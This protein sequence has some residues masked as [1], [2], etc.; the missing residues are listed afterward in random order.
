[1]DALFKRK[2][3]SLRSP[4]VPRTFS[5]ALLGD[6]S[7]LS[8]NT[9]PKV[10]IP[11]KEVFSEKIQ[12]IESLERWAVEKAESENNSIFKF[13]GG[14]VA[15][16]SEPSWEVKGFT[17]EATLFQS[18]KLPQ[19]FKA[20]VLKGKKRGAVKVLFVSE[21]FRLY[22]EVEPEFKE[23]FINELIVGFPLKTAELFERMIAA[24]KLTPEE[25]IIF[26]V[27]GSDDSDYSSDVMEMAAYYQPEVIIPLG[28]T[29]TNKILKS[30]DRLT[31]VH[32]K[33]YS[34]K[35]GDQTFQVVPLFHPRIIETNKNHKKAA[36][37]DMQ[38]I[39]HFLKKVP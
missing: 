34:R 33:F 13:E 39:M 23:G 17:E 20:I 35:T 6:T 1:M 29:A 28:A 19:E 8:K 31:T 7:W 25:V 37:E 30:N 14:E 32:G 12:V 2:L 10:E 38:K 3:L 22:S 11:P 26:P 36:W 27:E 21:K 4:D 15:L 24:M 9:A 16:K 5:D 18:L